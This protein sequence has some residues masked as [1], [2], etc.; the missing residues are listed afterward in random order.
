MFP[1][2]C[3]W[4]FQVCAVMFMRVVGVRWRALLAS[5]LA[6]LTRTALHSSFAPH[7]AVQESHCDAHL[8]GPNGEI[9]LMQ[10]TKENCQGNCWDVHTNIKLGGELFNGYLKEAGGNV[11]AAMG[12]YN[13]WHKGMTKSDA[14]S[15]KY[16]CY[17]QNNLD[18]LDSMVNGWLQGKDGY[19]DQFR[20]YNKWVSRRVGRGVVFKVAELNPFP[21]PTLLLTVSLDAATKRLPGPLCLSS[22]YPTCPFFLIGAR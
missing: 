11:L 12:Q 17:A 16:G 7:A 14:M 4:P 3:S 8:H 18:Y 6:F 19:G 5:L 15:T 22:S 2:H 1:P 9:G 10:L 20:T 21:L 13:G